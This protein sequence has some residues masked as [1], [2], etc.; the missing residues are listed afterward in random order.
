MRRWLVAV[1]EH[2]WPLPLIWLATVLEMLAL[3]G[4]FRFLPIDG[5]P[6]RSWTY[7]FI[8]LVR[9]LSEQVRNGR[10]IHGDQFSGRTI[11]FGPISDHVGC[12]GPDLEIRSGPK[13]GLEGQQLGPEP[14][15]RP[16]DS[17]TFFWAPFR[18]FLSVSFSLHVQEIQKIMSTPLTRRFFWHFQ[19]MHEIMSAQTQTWHPWRSQE[20]QVWV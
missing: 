9:N 13:R 4:C 3:K 18:N 15:T 7:F 14:P 5:S 16:A 10:R 8:S 11:D 19:E 2:L 6:G 1:G 17:G 20:C 12:F